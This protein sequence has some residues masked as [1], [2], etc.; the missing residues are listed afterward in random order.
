[1]VR[2]QPVRR[3]LT[4]LPPSPARTGPPWQSVR[5]RANLPVANE[6]GELVQDQPGIR[7]RPRIPG[8]TRKRKPTMEDPDVPPLRSP[9]QAGTGLAK[10]SLIVDQT[11]DD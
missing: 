3:L 10:W 7:D 1:M 8:M 2:F 6:V 5:A 4:I 11:P 9:A